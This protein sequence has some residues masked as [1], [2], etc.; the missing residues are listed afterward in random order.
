MLAPS[1]EKEASGSSKK[2]SEKA[3]HD[4]KKEGDN[5]KPEQHKTASKSHDL[6]GG[7]ARL[8]KRAV[9][10]RYQQ[11]VDADSDDPLDKDCE[12]PPVAAAAAPTEEPPKPRADSSSDCPDP[13]TPARRNEFDYQEL[14]DEYGSRKTIKAQHQEYQHQFDSSDQSHTYEDTG[15]QSMYHLN[16]SPNPKPPPPPAQQEQHDRIVGHEYGVKPL[17]DD[18][19]LSESETTD[20]TANPLPGHSSSRGSSAMSVGSIPTQGSVGVITPPTPMSPPVSEDVFRAAPFSGRKQKKGKGQGHHQHST[21]IKSTSDQVFANVPFL[22]SAKKNALS[23]SIQQTEHNSSMTFVNPG[24]FGHSSADVFSQAPFKFRHGS[25]TPTKMA[26]GNNSVTASPL[27]VDMRSPS[28]SPDSGLQTALIQGSSHAHHN[29]IPM[30]GVSPVSPASPYGQHPV[31][32]FGSGNFGEMSF[33]EAQ[34]QLMYQKHY[35]YHPGAAG[36]VQ[37]QPRSPHGNP[38]QSLHSPPPQHM[39][40]PSPQQQVAPQNPPTQDLFGD[41][42]FSAD[43]VATENNN[44][45][46]QYADPKR[47]VTSV[48]CGVRK[49]TPTRPRKAS[50]SRLRR[51]GSSSSGSEGKPSP[52]SSKRESATLKSKHF[53]RSSE[54]LH[55]E[56][57]EVLPTDSGSLKRSKHKPK[58]GG[59]GME[60]QSTAFSN[61]SFMDDDRD[62]DS[63]MDMVVPLSP[64]K[65]ESHSNL[66]VDALRNNQ[67]AN[68]MDEGSNTLPKAGS[69]KHRV[70]PCT[71][72]PKLHRVLP[73]TPD[74]E[75][76]SMKKRG[77]FK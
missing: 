54:L 9:E 75:P 74:A 47:H 45:R 68:Y 2:D 41:V 62:A 77:L 76:F 28:L 24:A 64:I 33:H 20:K 71:P 58:K 37:G 16:K 32:L 52:R 70:L 59:S 60:Y 22:K 39:V 21:P 57:V 61:L 72:D 66:T 10:S 67:A 63:S 34:E 42:P 18:D 27:G 7:T 15:D 69:K 65:S 49:T 13:P 6:F 73:S 43:S 55:D 30:Q 4:N 46:K 14:D 11:F 25:G 50:G 1:N 17:L 38:T 51:R 56:N 40:I 31:D 35:D 29:E 44:H 36:W 19:E 3:K 12:P 26:G 23:P 8:M 53:S 48:P 5:A